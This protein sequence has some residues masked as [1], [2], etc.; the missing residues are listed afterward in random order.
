MAFEYLIDE[1]L[2]I[3]GFVVILCSNIETNNELIH[4]KKYYF[5]SFF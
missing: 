5:Q 2:E 4:R 3:M 1:M